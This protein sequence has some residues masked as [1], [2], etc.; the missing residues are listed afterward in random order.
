MTTTAGDLYSQAV[1]GTSGEELLVASGSQKIAA[2]WSP[3]GEHLAYFEND[4]LWIYPVGGEAYPFL[5]TPALERS[6]RF[7][8]DGRWLAY[9]S[10]ETGDFE[11]YVRPF[12][13]PGPRVGISIG[14]GLSPR[15]SADGAQLF[16]RQGEAMLAVPLAYD[17]GVRAASPEVLFEADFRLDVMGH[18]RYGV[19]P[20]GEHFLMVLP[21]KDVQINFHAGFF[22]ELKRLVPTD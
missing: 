16:Y 8:A 4:D 6:P 10:D 17:G 19:A 13:G 18:S 1:D 12:P 11:V 22:E 3:D 20:D 15:W 9:V 21:G 5:A 7:S 2:S 14:G